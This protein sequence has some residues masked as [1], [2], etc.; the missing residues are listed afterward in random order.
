MNKFHAMALACLLF[1]ALSY[2]QRSIVVIGSSTAAGDGATVYD[3]S[4]IGRL[5]KHYMDLGLIDVVYNRATPGLSTKDCLPT[6]PSHLGEGQYPYPDTGRDVTK[7]ISY[8]PLPLLVIISLPSNDVTRGIPMDT[9]LLN[10]RTMYNYV[11]A[12]GIPC[13]VTNTQPRDDIDPA[14]RTYQQ[15]AGDSILAEFP[16]N[17]MDFWDTLVDPATLGI[18]TAFQFGDGIHL[19]N[20]GHNALY[21]KALQYGNIL[22]APLIPLPLTLV[23]FE[24][25]TE[26]RSAVLKIGRAHV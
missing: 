17:S 11:T 7:A 22:S 25:R 16:H 26:Q 13:I 19:N 21:T 9:F 3:S 14:S 6:D 20:A 18:K 4:W 12:A 23:S 1:P 10:L 24:G 2:A 5:T 8:R 15:T